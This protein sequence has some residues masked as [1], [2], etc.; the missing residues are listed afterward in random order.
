MDWDNAI[1]EYKTYLKLE[2]NLSN[3]TIDNYLGD[4]YKLIDF[5]PELDPKN[6]GS[7]HIR[8]FNY[9]LGKK[10]AT[11]SQARMLSGIR[12]FFDFLIEE[13]VREDNPAMHIDIPKFGLYLPDTLNK[14]EIDKIVE[15][16]DLS[17]KHGERNK[18]ILEMLYGCGLR[19]SE[20]VELKISDLFL[21]EDFIR[22]IGKGNKQ[23]LVPVAKYTQK[24]LLNYIKLVRVHLKINLKYT[25]HIFINN[26]GN[27][28]S[29]VMVYN[30]VKKQV[31]LA[32]ISK[33]VSPHTFR[34]S[35]ATHLLENGAD[36]RSIQI[37]LGHESI[38]TTEIYTHIDK[39]FVRDNIN[40][41]H[42]RR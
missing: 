40:K 3:N 23:R 32:G 8:E 19:V 31:E 39:S 42:P 37:M 5:Y 14:Y 6:I 33:N 24:V 13:E 20:L 12:S 36:L 15:T 26:R 10:Y 9:Q 2:R 4:I 28:L 11:R 35:F 25:D 27:N 29:R 16:I 41:Y 17:E 18:A 34:H 7:E 38:S 22:V 21:D 30:I 1:N